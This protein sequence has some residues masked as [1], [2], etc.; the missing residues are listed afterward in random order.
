MNE[1]LYLPYHS[2]NALERMGVIDGQKSEFECGVCTKCCETFGNP[3]FVTLPDI[4][5]LS[6][7]LGISMNDF[8]ERYLQVGGASIASW[9][10]FK[11]YPNNCA[12]LSVEMDMPCTLLHKNY[13]EDRGNNCTVYQVAFVTCKLPPFLFYDPEM[14]RNDGKGVVVDSI[15]EYKC[16][17][18][19]Y[20]SIDDVLKAKAFN[21]L[22]HREFNFTIGT[23]YNPRMTFTLEQATRFQNIVKDKKDTDWYKQEA[24]K[25]SSRVRFKLEMYDMDTVVFMSLVRQEMRNQFKDEVNRRLERLALDTTT[26]DKLEGFCEEYRRIFNGEIP[27]HI[28]LNRS[29]LTFW[30]RKIKRRKIRR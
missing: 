25:V 8:F 21:N 19:R 1:K 29:L 12:P 23:L 16:A 9:H 15:S 30:P 10:M 13:R 11:P 22:F 3:V 24:Q 4:H 20:V 2:R 17:A 14:L 26:V 6:K 27:P 28:T 5:R 18:N 7:H